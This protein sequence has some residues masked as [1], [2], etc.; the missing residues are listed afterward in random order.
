MAKK[1]AAPPPVEPKQFQS[2]EE[3][4]HGIAKL[5]RRIHDLEQLDVRRDD[6][7]VSVAESDVRET[8]RDVFGTNSP[9]FTQHAHLRL[10]AGGLYLNMPPQAI[11]RAHEGGRVQ[12]ITTIGGLISRLKEKREDLTRGVAAPSTYFDRL[13]LHPRILDVSRDLFLDGYHWEA[14]FAAASVDIQNRPLMD[15]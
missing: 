15:T 11:L 5:E 10:W 7:A 4:D 1:S 13:N 6:G 3:V 8:I 2:V 9:E 14:V 12:A